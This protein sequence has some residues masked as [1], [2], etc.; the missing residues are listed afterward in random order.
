M[1][2][3]MIKKCLNNLPR[4]P[5]IHKKDPAKSTDFT[6]DHFI[7]KKID[8]KFPA[9]A[10]PKKDFFAEAQKIFIDIITC[11]QFGGAIKTKV[12]VDEDEVGRPSE[13][14]RN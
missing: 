2:R 9:N 1:P 4:D 3:E 6:P 14:Y 7:M 5:D 13:N 12:T 11:D 10:M 8:A